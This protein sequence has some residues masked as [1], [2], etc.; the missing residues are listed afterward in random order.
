VQLCIYE[1]LLNYSVIIEQDILCPG[2]V[3]DLTHPTQ[4]SKGHGLQKTLNG[5]WTE[6]IFGLQ[7]WLFKALLCKPTA[8]IPIEKYKQTILL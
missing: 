8:P 4:D 7:R 6:F 2:V 3:F 5:L 1:K